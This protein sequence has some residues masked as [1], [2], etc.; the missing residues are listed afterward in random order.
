[1]LYD[2]ATEKYYHSPVSPHVLFIN[3][4]FYVIIFLFKKKNTLIP[5]WAIIYFETCYFH[6]IS[7]NYK[8]IFPKKKLSSSHL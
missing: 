8:I 1:M 3:L 5:T 4:R 7:Y 2:T 6:L